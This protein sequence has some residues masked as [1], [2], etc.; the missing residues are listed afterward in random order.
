MVITVVEGF[1][2]AWTASSRT[3]PISWTAMIKVC[4]VMGYKVDAEADC[5][6]GR[7]ARVDVDGGCGG[8]FWGRLLRVLFRSIMEGCC[9]SLQRCEGGDKV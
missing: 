8:I 9:R 5:R 3:W 2:L 4:S 1:Q 6:K 7:C